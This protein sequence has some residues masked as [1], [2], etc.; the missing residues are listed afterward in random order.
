[1]AVLES[2]Q[3]LPLVASEDGTIRIAGTRV[4]LDSVVHHYDQGATAE[5]IA[6]RFPAL[7]LADVHACLAYYLNHSAQVEAYLN[8]QRR[9]ADDLQGRISADP[10]QREGLARMR[11]RIKQR[12]AARQE[13]AS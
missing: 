8:D 3:Q 1:M 7:R 9:R 4:S 12:L 11:E 6:L 5:E 13:H 2:T 10:G